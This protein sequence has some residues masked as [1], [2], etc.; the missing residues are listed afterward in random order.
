M[1]FSFITPF[2]F[3]LFFQSNTVPKEPVVNLVVSHEISLENRYDNSYVN[4]IFKDNILLNMAYMRGVVKKAD[5]IVWSTIEK[6]FT[7][8]FTLFPNSTFTFHDDV[9]EKYKESVTVTSNAHF[10]FQEGFKSDGY[11]T[12]DGVCHLASL[13]YWAAKDA[14]LDVYAPTNHDFREIPEIDKKYGVSIYSFP[15]STAS[16]AMQ[17]LYITNNKQNPVEFVFGYDGKSLKV[18]IYEVQKPT[19]RERLT[20]S[21]PN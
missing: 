14:G 19:S 3:F 16:N 15:G 20:H 4:G 11:L 17:N 6:P 7:Y 2:L 10:N 1:I 13:I 21:L 12:G 8:K 5:D 9:L 18:S